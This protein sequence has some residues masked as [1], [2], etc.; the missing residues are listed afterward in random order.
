MGQ[1][2]QLGAPLGGSLA[3]GLGLRPASGG[4]PAAPTVQLLLVGGGGAG[5]RTSGSSNST[6]HSTSGGAGGQVLE[7]EIAAPGLGAYAVTI[8]QGGTVFSANAFGGVTRFGSLLTAIGGGGGGYGYYGSITGT[9]VFT[10]GFNSCGTGGYSNAPR[11]HGGFVGGTFATDY[12]T[13]RGGPGGGGAGGAG[14][15]ANTTTGGAPGP[16]KFSSISGAPVEYGKGG[17]GGHTVGGAGPAASGPG[18]GGGGAVPGS[19][20]GGSNGNAGILIL[21]YLTGTQTWTGGT[22]TTVGPWTIHTCTADTTLT[23]TA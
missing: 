8:G 4:A 1:E 20:T 16:G 6:G 5:D 21:R 23:R 11:A 13:Y 3:G 18:G 10:S 2:A 19:S 12:S 9:D 22:I 14:G 7:V 17:Q 15:N